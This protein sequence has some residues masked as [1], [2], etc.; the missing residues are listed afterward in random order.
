M[1]IS[2]ILGSLRFGNLEKSEKIDDVVWVGT[3][4]L[5]FNVCVIDRFVETSSSFVCVCV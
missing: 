4:M 5:L 2:C 1:I 3:T